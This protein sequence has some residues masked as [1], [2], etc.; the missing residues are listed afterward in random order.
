MSDFSYFRFSCLYAIQVGE[1][2]HIVF[3][4]PVVITE[5]CLL[6]NSN[7]AETGLAISSV[8]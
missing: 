1:S 7:T 2:Q 5:I 3:P 6:L 4:E 8:L